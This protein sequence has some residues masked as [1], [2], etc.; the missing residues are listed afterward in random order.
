MMIAL[1]WRNLRRNRLRTVLTAS[2]IGFAVLLVSF[3]M[4]LQSGS[5]DVM[6]ESA[7]E[8]FVGHGQISSQQFVER[9]R[10]QY[11]V[12]NLAALTSELSAIAGLRLAPRVQA[13][14]VISVG[15]RSFGGLVLGIDFAAEHQVWGLLDSLVQGQLPA[16]ADD[17]L[18]GIGL[19]RNL[20]VVVGDEIVVLGTGKQGSVGALALRVS[21][22]IKTGLSEMDRGLALAPIKTVQDGFYMGDEAHMVSL[23]VE[24]YSSMDGALEKVKGALPNDLVLRTWRELMPEIE[25]AIELDKASATIFYWILMILV[26]FAALN[27]FVMVVYERTREF[28]MLLALGMRPWQIIAQVQ[29]EA[30][31]LSLLG[32]AGGLATSLCLVGY[33]SVNGIP[34]SAFAAEDVQQQMQMGGIEFIY[35]VASL[36]AMTLSPAVMIVGTQV[37]A[38]LNML[39]IRKIHPVQALRAE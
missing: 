36:Y 35:P 30:L 13:F 8:F 34:L 23:I 5:Y 7:T 10:F 39:R 15:E 2:G 17:V 22:I 6:R 27:T 37:M 4:S 18:L 11:T 25:Q 19:A 24:D 29:I 28:G 31:L 26:S 21:G 38:F 32:V 12:E 16:A 33:L 1:A 3:A 20:G 9:E 14:G